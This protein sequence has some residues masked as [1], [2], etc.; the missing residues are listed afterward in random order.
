MFARVFGTGLREFTCLSTKR[1][2]RK[3]HEPFTTSRVVNPK[4]GTFVA[5][6][7]LCAMRVSKRPKLSSKKCGP[8]S[9]GRALGTVVLLLARIYGE[10]RGYGFYNQ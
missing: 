9:G 3:P 4:P 5:V 8:Y 1:G 10:S 6:P 7:A 2:V